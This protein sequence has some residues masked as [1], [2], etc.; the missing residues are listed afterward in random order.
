MARREGKVKH[1]CVV[2]SA[3][4]AASGAA[5]TLQFREHPIAE[6]LTGAY[7]VVA[8]DL[9]KDGRPDLIALA[10]NLSELV[11]FENPGWER[12]VI[13]SGLTQPINVDA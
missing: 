8:V 1:W 4:I 3:A 5:S 10:S 9:N 13:A 6:D 2:L 12:H 7:Q 11:W